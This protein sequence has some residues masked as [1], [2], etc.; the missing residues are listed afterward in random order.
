[1]QGTLL[2][3]IKKARYQ[4][5]YA[6]PRPSPN[7][8]LPQTHARSSAVQYKSEIDIIQTFIKCPSPLCV[9]PEALLDYNHP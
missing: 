1:M 9:T 3:V 6:V 2:S 4:R 5:V 7:L 8:T